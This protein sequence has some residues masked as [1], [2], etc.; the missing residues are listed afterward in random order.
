MRVPDTLHY[1]PHPEQVGDLYL[2]DQ[3]APT[4]VVLLHGGFWRQ[5]YGRD[6]YRLVAEDLRRRGYAVW[7]LE[8]RRVPAPGSGW[9]GTFEDVRLGVAHL[10]T[11][12]PG[13]IDPGRVFVCGHSAGGHLA[14]WVGARHA[15]LLADSGVRVLGVIGQA[16]VADLAEAHR[17]GLGR[18][19]VAELMALAPA[20]APD[21]YREASPVARLP[22]GVPQLVLQG[23]LDDTVPPRLVAGY[24]DAAR[25][26][27]D[28]VDFEL[29]PG[30]GHMEFL[31]P[32]SPCHAA[33]CRWLTG[34]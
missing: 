6:Q 18:G 32:G 25:L 31:D 5:P 16:P 30:L 11:L 2:P 10:G 27:G 26:A 23:A 15:S 1:G 8:Y 22:L 12:P 4:V 33:L 19:A 24:A 14:L 7:N 29:L 9:P 21:R 17:L 13:T 34:R 3:D 28:M 20:D